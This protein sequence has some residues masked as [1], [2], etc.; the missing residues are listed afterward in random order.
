M[1][2]AGDNFDYAEFT[3]KVRFYFYCIF[4]LHKII[5]ICS[6]NNNTTENLCIYEV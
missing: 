6:S 1:S 4:Y 2:T 5:K 3:Q